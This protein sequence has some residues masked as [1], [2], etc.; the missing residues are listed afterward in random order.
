MRSEAHRAKSGGRASSDVLDEEA[1]RD[2]RHVVFGRL[3]AGAARHI[4]TEGGRAGRLSHL[5]PCPLMDDALTRRDKPLQQAGGRECRN[6]TLEHT[7]QV[8]DCCVEDPD[9]VLARYHTDRQ[10]E[11]IEQIPPEIIEC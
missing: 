4:A 5:P 1:C 2:R 9:A 6:L 8:P 11:V 7:E 10:V 3:S